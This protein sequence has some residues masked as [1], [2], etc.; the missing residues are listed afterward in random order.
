M[1]PNDPLSAPRFVLSATGQARGVLLVHGFSGSPYELHL[2]ADRLV[3]EGYSVALPRLAGHHQSLRALSES[4]WQDWL[5]SAEQ[6]LL[7]LHR[8]ILQETQKTPQLAVVGFSMG[9]LL[10]LELARR[11]PAVPTFARPDLPEVRVLSV[12]SSPLWLPPWQEKAIVRLAG[13]A[14][15]RGLAVPKL[16]GRDLRAKDLPKAPLRPWGMPVRAL[17][18]LVELMRTVRPRLPEVQQPTLLAHGQLDHTVPVACV[19]ALAEELG[20]DAAHKHKLILPRSYH[21]VPLD[22]ERE[23]LFAALVAHLDRYLG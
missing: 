3:A 12:L 18:S 4:T 16:A 20:T 21:I 1:I 17:A 9:G 2:L 22:V 5:S 19:E 23:E 14:G 8:R 6:A 11:Y 10:A 13:S 7:G 15:L